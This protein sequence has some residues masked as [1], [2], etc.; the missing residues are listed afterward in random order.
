V[1]GERSF[2]KGSVQNLWDFVDDSKLKLTISK[3]L[4]PGGRSIQSV[5]IPA[6]IEMLPVI[7]QPADPEKK[8]DQALALVYWRELVRREAD[9]DKH[10]DKEQ[11]REEKP[12]YSFTYL[13]PRDLRRKS[14]DIDLSKDEQVQFA[15]DVL[16]AASNYRRPELLASAHRVVGRYEKKGQRAIEEAFSQLDVDWSSGPSREAADLEV[17]VDFGK[18]GVLQAGQYEQF[19]I[20]VTN[21]GPETLYQLGALTKSEN[22]V[23]DDGEF[24]YGRLGPGETKSYSRKVW[25]LT[26]YASEEA[27]LEIQFRDSE[28]MELFHYSPTVRVKD[29]KLPHLSWNWRLDDT[30]HGNGD[31]VAQPGE[32]IDVELEVSNSGQG[33]TVEMFARIKNKSGRALDIARGSLEPGY[34]VNEAGERCTPVLPGFENGVLIGDASKD[35]KRVELE[36]PATFEKGCKRKLFPGES[37]TGS[38]LVEAKG[39]SD[40]P[41]HVEVSLGDAEAY[42]HA[43]I[44][45]LGFYSYFTNESDVRFELG[46]A[47]PV[48]EK[49]IL[50]EV[51]IS[52]RPDRVATS[53][54]A[55][56]SGAVKDDKGVAYVMV[57]HG[58]DKVF[59]EGSGKNSRLE[60]I[61]YS[62]ELNL[63]PGMNVVTVLATDSQGGKS[64][65][66]A[67]VFYKEPDLKAEGIPV[68]TGPK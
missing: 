14:A 8:D 31:G 57:F 20:T 3:Y 5:G 6:D 65:S 47:L 56:I 54:I 42:D 18:D 40:T 43:S 66:S 21:N 17:T 48:G 68:E 1:I 67:V 55:T 7:L 51:E 9:L 44:V 60:L 27:P 63:K 38:F 16:L 19:T 10:L 49:V 50:P 11:F 37:W 46:E 29:E 52:R 33:S 61:P 53:P 2:G 23:L 45:R 41:L 34:M 30:R 26:G 58:E 12:A 32:K 15:R 22:Q 64:T 28:N 39:E 25:V 24:F 62:A 35:P 59:F 4:T 13:R 36:E